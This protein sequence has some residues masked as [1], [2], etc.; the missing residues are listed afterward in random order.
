VFDRAQQSPPFGGRRARRGEFDLQLHLLKS[1]ISTPRETPS[2]PRTSTSPVAMQRT[3][4]N[5][6]RWCEATMRSVY[7]RSAPSGARQRWIA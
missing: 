1:D 7:A 2:V 6:S 5:G 4:S 3:A